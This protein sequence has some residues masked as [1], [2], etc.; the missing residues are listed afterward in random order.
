MTQPTRRL[1]TAVGLLLLGAAPA[2]QAQQQSPPGGLPAKPPA[3][4]AP[5]G[6]HVQREKSPP[7]ARHVEVPEADQPKVWHE[8]RAR[9]WEAEHRDWKARGGYH[10]Y[11]IP[12]ERF[13]SRFG[14]NHHFRVYGHPLVLMGRY[15]RFQYGDYWFTLMDPVPESWNDDWYR[16]DD[17]YIVWDDDAYYLRNVSHPDQRIA[18]TVHPM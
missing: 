6:T 16:T 7:A 10:G 2:M 17:V 13:D 5:G 9:N 14:R 18:L 1:A 12:D 8:R 15:P 3:N 11:R 4:V